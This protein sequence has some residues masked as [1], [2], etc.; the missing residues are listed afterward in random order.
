MTVALSDVPS[1]PTIAAAPD[2]ADWY[3]VTDVL[4]HRHWARKALAATT[5]I[6]SVALYYNKT[7]C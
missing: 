2:I 4:H 1:V 6:L 5:D 3:A 7:P